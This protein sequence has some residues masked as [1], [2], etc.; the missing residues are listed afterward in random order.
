MHRRCL[1]V[2]P[3]LACANKCVFCWRHHKNPVGTSW[4]WKVD[5]PVAIVEQA[6]AKHAREIK[7]LKGLPGINM[8]RWREAHM[9]RHCAVSHSG[10]GGGATE[11]LL[12]VLAT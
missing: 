4:R 5:D 1:Q 11:L 10:S 7:A 6:I 9:P 12:I 3:S 2:T 8:D